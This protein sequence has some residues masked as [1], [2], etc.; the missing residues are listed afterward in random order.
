MRFAL[1]FNGSLFILPFLDRQ[2]KLHIS[3]NRVLFLLTYFLRRW[4]FQN[5]F[6]ANKK[7][8][9]FSTNQVARTTSLF[10]LEPMEFYGFRDEDSRINFRTAVR[11]TV[12]Y[13]IFYIY[14]ITLIMNRVLLTPLKIF[15]PDLIDL[16]TK[17]DNI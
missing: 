12:T 8:G 11:L 14:L 6:G 16:N 17:S 15:T 1:V 10:Q 7:L 9:I 3:R 5:Y 2:H 13:S 4:L